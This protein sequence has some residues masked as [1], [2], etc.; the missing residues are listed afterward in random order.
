[1]TCPVCGTPQQPYAPGRMP[2]PVNPGQW[3]GGPD[4]GGTPQPPYGPGRMPQPGNP[5]QWAGGPDMGG[6]PQPP[7]GPGRIQPPGNPGQRGNRPPLNPPPK[8]KGN[9]QI[10]IILGTLAATI[11]IV[12][13]VIFIPK[14]TSGGRKPGTE[15]PT[16]DPGKTT[17]ERPTIM[18]TTSTTEEPVTEKPVTEQPTTEE[19]ATE[20]ED[21]PTEAELTA[22]REAFWNYLEKED[23]LDLREA[24]EYGGA[25]CPDR[26]LLIDLDWDGYPEL[27]YGFKYA[28][29]MEESYD[30]VQCL[31][32]RNG[33][34][35]TEY[36]S[37]HITYDMEINI[38]QT[39]AGEEFK[40]MDQFMDVFLKGGR[41]E[42]V[43]KENVH[44]Y[45]L[46]GSFGKSDADQKDCYALVGEYSVKADKT[47][48]EWL[49]MRYYD[50]TFYVTISFEDTQYEGY[51]TGNSSGK[52][53]IL[54][55]DEGYGACR[56]SGQMEL[57]GDVIRLTDVEISA[58]DPEGNV[59]GQ[60]KLGTITT[61]SKVK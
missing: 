49:R 50:G 41:R 25:T 8:K 38:L 12:L 30:V 55:N 45:I 34:I 3:A 11:L 13:L 2:Q 42:S 28:F 19:P 18:P 33:K 40:L 48:V 24:D 35:G 54:M 43:R 9:K 36:L 60:Q 29:T 20:A 31:Y 5:G 56:M 26:V 58:R 37:V 57:S 6:T 17:T 10:W 51:G 14:W 46:T 59:S 23:M 53:D 22:C 1:M 27:L 44:Q 39:D 47:G 16:D 21:L 4:M 15:R 32:Y 7:Y 52:I 61:V